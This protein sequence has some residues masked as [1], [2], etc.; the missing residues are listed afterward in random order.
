[1]KQNIV[2]DLLKTFSEDEI[3][4]FDDY[5]ESPFFNKSK[6]LVTLY[7]AIIKHHPDYK[8]PSLEKEKLFK[9]IYP[10]KPYHEQN[11][12]NRL[13]ELS[14]M[15]KDFIVIT[16]VKQNDISKKH[17]YIDELLKRKKFK[18]AEQAFKNLMQSLDE[19]NMRDSDTFLYKLQTLERG[20]MIYLLNDDKSP[21]P[22][23]TN[24]QKGEYLINYFVIYLMHVLHDLVNGQKSARQ[25]KDITSITEKFWAVDEF[26]KNFDMKNFLSKLKEVNYKEY[27]ILSI[28]YNMYLSF[29]N[30][31]EETYFNLKESVFEEFDKYSKQEQFNFISSLLH[32]IYNTASLR[33]PKFHKE[34]L[35]IN[36]IALE[37]NIYFL[38]KYKARFPAVLFWSITNNAM[39]ADEPDW[40]EGFVK[41]YTPKLKEEEQESLYNFAMSKIYF[42]RKMFNECIESLSKIDLSLLPT[43]TDKASIK[44][45]QLINY[46]EVNA[47]V[48]V[49]SLIDTYRHFIKDN[50]KLPDVYKE[51]FRNF[52]KYFSIVARAKFDDKSVD[53]A[54]YKELTENE[55]VMHKNWLEE[56]MKFYVK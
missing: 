1:M 12:R 8:H 4:R 31:G 11:L 28:Y 38:D 55:M 17:T 13:T 14:D 48:Q 41:E 24:I 37:K 36:K 25:G 19:T 22:I 44:I 26:M 23:K 45:V 46:F 52:L 40:L 30:E 39:L 3:K 21:K 43:E 16:H 35:D 5:L 49:F 53:Y 2:I 7:R 54:D 47:H 42:R 6:I 56:K 51:R 34:S 50:K 20:S 27:N 33:T 10:G 18:L 9:K 32:T 15:V 29:I